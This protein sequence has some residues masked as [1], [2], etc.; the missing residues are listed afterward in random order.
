[1]SKVAI[2]TDSNSGITQADGKEMGVFVLP[3]PFYIDDELFFEE[4]TLTQEEF[5]QK[6]ESDADIKTS[7]PAPGDVMKLWDDILKEYDEIVHIPMSSGLSGSCETAMM[8]AEEYD[9]KVK[10]VNNQRIS[11]TQRRSVMEAKAL[12]DAGKNAEEIK[13]LLEEIKLESDIYI[14]L[15]TL[16]YLKKGGRLTPAAAAIGTVLNL[17]PV[18]RIKGEK[19][20][21]FSKARGWKSAKKTMIQT[22]QKVIDT[23]FSDCKGPENLYIDA[24]YTG[25]QE[26]ANEWKRELEETFPEYDIYMAPLSLSVACH[27]G[28]GAR[29]VTVTKRLKVS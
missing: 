7:Q 20:D 24:A 22:I 19:L 17:K 18:L 23:E 6:M 13:A 10:V 12:A 9:G 5:Y 15:D 8:L 28:P 3:M 25:N 2:V 26:D 27:I 29:A 16:K 14:T 4:I 1:M 11:V 21:A